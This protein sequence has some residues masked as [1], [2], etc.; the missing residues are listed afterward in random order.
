M[1]HKERN[2]TESGEVRN[3]SEKRP[4]VKGALN[5]YIPNGFKFRLVSRFLS[6][7][8]KRKRSF[9]YGA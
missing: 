9:F 3:G 6:F 7:A 5:R 1:T 4:S 2:R 8:P